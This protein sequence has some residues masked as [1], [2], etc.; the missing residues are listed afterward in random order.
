LLFLKYR[1]NENEVL[2]FISVRYTI[3]D[4]QIQENLSYVPRGA[5]WSDAKT[6]FSAS[7]NTKN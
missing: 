6:C 3:T 7:Q 2:D 1:P 5:K 4:N